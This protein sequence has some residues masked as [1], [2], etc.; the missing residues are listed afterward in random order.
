[1]ATVCKWL[2]DFPKFT[3][4]YTRAREA[5]ADAL[6]DEILEIADEAER[7]IGKDGKANHELVQRARLRVDARKWVAAKMRPKKY[8][9]RITAEVSGPD[10]G[11]IQVDENTVAARISSLLATATL[12][13]AGEADDDGADLV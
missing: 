5:Q 9:E 11:A 8:G 7:D 1:M 13:K 6:V 10:G 3:E 4:Q 12:R 2:V